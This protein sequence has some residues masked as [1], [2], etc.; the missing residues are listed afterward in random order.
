MKTPTTDLMS[1]DPRILSVRTVTAVRK[2]KPCV[3]C[4]EMILAKAVYRVSVYDGFAT[5]YWHPECYR[6]TEWVEDFSFEPGSQKRGI[7]NP[8]TVYP[9]E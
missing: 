9:P 8:E 5:D 3:W 7:Y 1:D 2:T 4:G 6:E